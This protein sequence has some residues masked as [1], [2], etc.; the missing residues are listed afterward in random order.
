MTLKHR[1]SYLVGDGIW[2]DGAVLTNPTD[3]TVL[4]DTGQLESGIYL[5]AAVGAGSVAWVY[6]LQRR[7]AA[8]ATTLNSQRRRPA[9]GNEDFLLANKITLASNERI[10]CVLSGAVT[11]EVE[12]SIFTLDVP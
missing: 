11:G 2:T 8:K 3:G 5:V 1:P 9:A 10:R 4:A 6:D 12:M 7:D